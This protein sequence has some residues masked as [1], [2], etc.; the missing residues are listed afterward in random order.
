MKYR[1]FALCAGLLMSMAALANP[2][3]GDMH[4]SGDES[5]RAGLAS[6]MMQRLKPLYD[7]GLLDTRVHGASGSC[8]CSEYADVYTCAA[9]VNIHRCTKADS[10][11][12]WFSQ[13]PLL[14]GG[15]STTI[16]QSPQR[17][18]TALRRDVLNRSL[19]DAGNSIVT[20]VRQAA[21]R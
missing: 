4:S 1:F 3:D 6:M 14:Y 10:G 19:M 18:T 9:T 11:E 20:G 7:Q 17:K 2:C 15:T 12:V 16:L 8:S 5:C 13:N 21:R